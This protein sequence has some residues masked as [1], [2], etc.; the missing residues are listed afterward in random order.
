[1]G[2]QPRVDTL[3][4]DA[5]SSDAIAGAADADLDRRQ[6]PAIAARR[7]IQT[8]QGL[9]THVALD[10]D[11]ELLLDDPHVLG[12]F[13]PDAPVLGVHHQTAGAAFQR[14]AQLLPHQM[15]FQQWDAAAVFAGP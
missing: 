6:G 5:Q 14:R 1:M 3:D 11:G 15:F 12:Q 9:V 4:R 10:L 2:N 13:A 8:L 7:L